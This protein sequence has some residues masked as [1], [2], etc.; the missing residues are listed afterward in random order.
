MQSL[1]VALGL[2][3]VV[4][5]GCALAPDE[6]ETEQVAEVSAAPSLSAFVLTVKANFQSDV[7]VTS[8][9][10]C[11]AGATCNYAFLQGTT[12]TVETALENR[13]D[14]AR[15]TAWTGACAGQGPT[16]TLVMNSDLS[17][18]VARYKFG[19]PGCVPR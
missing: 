19:I 3:G 1:P 18:T 7:S 14:C 4:L 6:V 10:P 15:F 11:A 17:T 16:C 12:V 13:I 5:G 9:S 2:I 8:S